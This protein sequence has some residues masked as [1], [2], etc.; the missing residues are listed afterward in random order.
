MDEK[1][2]LTERVKTWLIGQPR[3]LADQTVFKH[4]SLVAFLAWV[5]LGADGLSSSCYGPAEAFQNLGEHTYLAVF[6]AMAV[7][8]TVFVISTCYSHII[9]EFPSGGGGYLVASKLLGRRVGLVSGCALLVDYVLTITVSIA[10]AGDAL[11]G[12]LGQ[13]L[14]SWHPPAVLHWLLPDEVNLKLL[15]EVVAI[16]VLIILN[17]RG[18]KESVLM[19]MPVFVLFLVTHAVLIIGA[20]ALNLTAVG[21]VTREVVEGVRTG[22]NDP[23]FGLWAMLALLLHAYSLGAGTYTGIEAVSNSMPVLREPRVATGKRTMLYMALSLA[24]TAGGLVLGYLLLGIKPASDKTMNQVL[25]E[26]FVT[27]LGVQGHWF[28]GA[29]ILAT[30]LSEGALLI[31]AA[32]AGFI[33]GPRVLANMAH[34]SWVPHRFGNLSERLAMHNGVLLMGGAALAALV[35]TKG[36]VTALVIM[37]SINVFV[38]FSLSMTGMCWHWF[39]Q[40][41]ENGLWRRRL[42]LFVVGATLCIS[43]LFVTIVEKFREGAWLTLAVTGFAVALCLCIRDQPTTA[44]PDPDQPTAVILVG[45]YGGLGLH[46]LLNAIR[47]MPGYF[48]NMAFISVGVVDSGAFKGARAVDDLR[49]STE[50]SLAKYVDLARGLGVPATSFM[51]IGTDV[52]DELHDLCVAVARQFPRATFFAGQLVFQEDKWYERLL[53]NETAY[54]L[55]RRLQWDGLP[56]VILPTRVR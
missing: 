29:F 18:V 27:G 3:D 15:A 33:D 20:I 5:G 53:H 52:V 12:L 41:G 26:S 54:S 34:D 23:E 31:V 21:D 2:R 32:Q 30:V 56:M 35:Y 11:F 50:E 51:A 24:L 47:F 16:F 45:G 9:E 46:T 1:P 10:A 25:T 39:R 4:P 49:R 6:L 38:T 55:Q 40:R 22:L 14:L 42:A 17:L 8:G 7:I 44:D 36:N 37:Y 19:L 48:R 13:E 43:I 28:G